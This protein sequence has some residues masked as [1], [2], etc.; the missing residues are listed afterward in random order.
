M[1]HMYMYHRR[2]LISL[3]AFFFFFFFFF[4]FFPSIS[5]VGGLRTA[6]GGVVCYPL[7]IAKGERVER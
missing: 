2:N 5:F 1:H 4:S 6:V 7:P 3:E